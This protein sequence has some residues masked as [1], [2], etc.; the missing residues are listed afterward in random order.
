MKLKKLMLTGVLVCGLIFAGCGGESETA[1]EKSPE[2]QAAWND[3]LGEESSEQNNGESDDDKDDD[4][5]ADDKR[6]QRM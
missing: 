5:V 6:T 1:K 4:D 3:I 2:I